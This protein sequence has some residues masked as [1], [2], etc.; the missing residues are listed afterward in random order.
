MLIRRQYLAGFLML[1]YLLEIDSRLVALMLFWSLPY[2]LKTQ[3]FNQLGDAK[4]GSERSTK[5]LKSSWQGQKP[6][7]VIQK[8]IQALQTMPLFHN[9]QM[10]RGLV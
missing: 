2:L 5:L 4:S 9:S 1:I 6:T 7:E 10:L 3:T 8:F